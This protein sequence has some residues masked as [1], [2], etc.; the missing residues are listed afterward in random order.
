MYKNGNEQ[1]KCT[2]EIVLFTVSKI[3]FG[4]FEHKIFL[5][6]SISKRHQR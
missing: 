1:V 4:A 2:M 3:A 6:F 5:F